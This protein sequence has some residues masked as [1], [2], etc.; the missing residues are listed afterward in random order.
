MAAN[1]MG[2]FEKDHVCFALTLYKWTKIRSTRV[3]SEVSGL[4]L[5]VL[6][7]PL[8]LSAIFDAIEIIDIPWWR[9]ILLLYSKL[10]SWKYV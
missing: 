10:F 1:Q 5:K 4:L 7:G 2:G 8:S 3:H 9:E 6:K